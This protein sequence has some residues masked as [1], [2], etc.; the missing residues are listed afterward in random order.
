[1][2]I[3]YN[4]LTDFV[5]PRELHR[6]AGTYFPYLTQSVSAEQIAH[7]LTQEAVYLLVHFKFFWVYFGIIEDFLQIF[8]L[9]PLIGPYR[10]CTGGLLGNP[11]LL[12]C[13]Q[14]KIRRISSLTHTDQGVQALIN[15]H[16]ALLS[17]ERALMC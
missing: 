11:C 9:K 17:V 12:L 5:H 7:F 2:H 10:T 13:T 4:C 14:G 16:S 3:S 15:T 8:L 1:M 6:S